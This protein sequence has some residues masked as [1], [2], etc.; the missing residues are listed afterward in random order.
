MRSVLEFERFTLTLRL[1]CKWAKVQARL[2]GS[3]AGFSYLSRC[4][5][6]SGSCPVHGLML[7]VPALCCQMLLASDSVLRHCLEAVRPSM[8]Y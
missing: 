8:P 4:I 7:R 1:D 5:L 2:A 3:A 6:G